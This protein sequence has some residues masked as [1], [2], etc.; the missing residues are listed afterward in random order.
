MLEK[1][2]DGSQSW[3]AKSI[4]V[5]VILSFA[6]A[7]ISSYLG[8]STAVPAATV[9]GEDI[10]KAELEQAY[11]SERNR[12]Q[13]QL[14]E[15][16]DTLSA[17]DGYLQTVRQQ[18]LDRL[19]AQKLVD[20]AAKKLGLTV[21]D[22][23]VKKAIFTEPA[24]QTDGKFD[25]DRYQALLRQ[26]G[27]QPVA[28]RNTM[29]N[30][31]TRRQLIEGT[32]GSEFALKGEAKQIAELQGQSRDI[33]YAIVNAEPFKADIKVSDEQAKEY[34]DTHQD[35]FIRPEMISVNYVELN[36]ADLAKNV[37]VTDAD[38]QAYYDEHKA[39]YQSQEKRLPAHILVQFG[40][41][42]AKAKAKIEEIKKEI[43]SGAD[44]AKLAEKD[45]EDTFSAKEGGKLDWYEHGVMDPAFD[46]AMF[47]LKKGQVSGV[48]ESEF[49]FHL[50]KL[51]DVQPSTTIEFAKVKQEIIQDLKKKQAD[52]EYYEQ[53]EQLANTS[54]E[55]P[56]SLTDTAKAVGGEVKHTALF[57]RNNVPAE[58]NNPEVIK[59]AFS[60]Q[61]LQDGMNSEVVDIDDS[62]S[63]VLR[64]NE[65]KVA[66]T[67]T[68][69]EVKSDIVARIA[70]EKANEKAEAKAKEFAASIK[71]DKSEVE[72]TAKSKLHRFDR[73]LNSAIVTKAFQMP[74]PKGVPSVDTV[75]LA[76]GFAVVVL[77]KV[78]TAEGIDDNVIASLQQ[79]LVNQYSNQDYTS[80]VAYLKAHA[81]IK[82]STDLDEETGLQ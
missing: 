56:D 27:Y 80:L 21:S 17:N 57:S 49:G 68:F 79:Q 53:K 78:N 38:A 71:A 76:D 23:Q 52:E 31:M 46:K 1:I 20:Q 66:G 6:F 3:V 15:M 11:Q 18:V 51:L 22:E 2:R 75:G 55:Q 54:Y 63:V 43:D 37:H 82:Y 65:H 28:F 74:A 61:V 48:V 24:F 47:E 25:N 13:Q 16:F 50:I 33:K 62:H 44:F 72:L 30:D 73:E 32:L 14:G 26:L 59:A 70:Q 19:V 5:L 58:L 42:K 45:S 8:S 39:E 81:E 9:N 10:S 12:L 4:L 69:D 40:D 29:R 35:Q 34:Y 60:D 77:D 64:V 7:G 36:S 67:K 41:D